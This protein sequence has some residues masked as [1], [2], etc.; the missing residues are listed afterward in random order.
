MNRRYGQYLLQ[1]AY[2]ESYISPLEAQDGSLSLKKR[3][4][5]ISPPRKKS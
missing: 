5:K 2:I 3:L 1:C 4:A